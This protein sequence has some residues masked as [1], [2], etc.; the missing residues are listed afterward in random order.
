VSNKVHHLYHWTP[1][2]NTGQS[3]T[4]GSILGSMRAAHYGNKYNRDPAALKYSSH[5]TLQN[6]TLACPWDTSCGRYQTIRQLGPHTGP[7]P[8]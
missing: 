7:P 2:I 1:L 6:L 8:S 5:G 3:D 4:I